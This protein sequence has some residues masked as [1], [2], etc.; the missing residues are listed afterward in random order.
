M[1]QGRVSWNS[2]CQRS[3]WVAPS[4]DAGA[5]VSVLQDP[6]LHPH[7]RGVLSLSPHAAW[8]HPQAPCM[9]RGSSM[10]CWGVS[11]AAHLKKPEAALICGQEP[12]QAQS[13][14]HNTGTQ[15]GDTRNMQQQFPQARMSLQQGDTGP[16]AAQTAQ[17]LGS[18]LNQELGP[19]AAQR[20]EVWHRRPAGH[21]HCSPLPYH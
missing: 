13:K 6:S 14:G 5:Q 1:S 4:L 9:E 3:R 8:W 12:G 18:H 20:A 2:C 11:T 19:K 17:S 15:L 21:P 16:W 10:G 7:S